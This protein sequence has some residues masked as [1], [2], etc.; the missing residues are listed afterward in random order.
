MKN[1]VK[2][3]QHAIQ[4]WI[5]PLVPAVVGVMLYFIANSLDLLHLGAAMLV[6]ASGV[7]SAAFLRKQHTAALESCVALSMQSCQE[8]Y[9]ADV[10][11]FF[12][13]LGR[14]ENEVTSLWARQI[15]T[16]RSQT[17]QAITELT[18]RFNAIVEKLNESV[19][20]SSL[21]AGSLDNTEGLVAV[22]TKSESQLESVTR[23]LREALG[24][25]ESL[26]KEVGALVQY[27]D[28]LSF[29]ASSVA[30]I[31]D[32]TNLLALNAAIEAARAGEAGR[33]FAVV[34]DEVRKL[35]TISGETGRRIRDTV[36]V[37]S[38]AISATFT[39]AEAYARTD[40][41]MEERAGS[42][43]QEV[44]GGF[45]Q[46]TQS[47]GESASLLRVS[48]IAI[49]NEVEESLIQF[50]FQDRVSQILSHVRDNI[51]TFPAYLQAGEEKFHEQG[52]LIAI[53]WSG[54]LNELERSYATREE[55]INHAGEQRSRT[56]A[57][58]HNEITFF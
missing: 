34:A 2:N 57:G 7:I 35:S 26:L 50:Q 4:V 9:R 28:E 42:V 19:L 30:S 31:A 36:K 15:E 48:S 58:A 3:K 12:A 13:G 33:G 55:L 14:L 52:R 40:M 39:A 49:K 56:T 53:D 45:R 6:V 1:K 20:A 46:V 5:Y 41:A 18:F 29:M 22:F 54:L 23:S 10:E 27:I 17:D 47:L 24:N 21:S 32:Q 51:N 8:K 37:I 25:K 43:I 38:N 11:S 44:L 16:G